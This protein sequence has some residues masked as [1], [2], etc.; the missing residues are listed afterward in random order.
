MYNHEKEDDFDLLT[1]IKEN[2]GEGPKIISCTAHA[3]Y[4]GCWHEPNYWL[5][6]E[7]GIRPLYVTGSLYT[8]LLPKE[9]EPSRVPYLHFTLEEFCKAVDLYYYNDFD[10]YDISEIDVSPNNLNGITA[11]LSVLGLK[12]PVWECDICDSKFTGI[13]R[14]LGYHGNG[15][16]GIVLTNPCCD[17][18][19][20]NLAFCGQC[21]ATD[22]AGYNDLG[23]LYCTRCESTA[24]VYP[25]DDEEDDNARAFGLTGSSFLGEEQELPPTEK[26]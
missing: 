23:E 13:A 6:Y 1:F 22:K 8:A 20:R 3:P 10:I 16:I 9:M 17:D 14:F 2:R 15:G 21:G 24:E 25:L 12:G 5:L 11:I 7:D 19:F 4:S 26:V 18:C